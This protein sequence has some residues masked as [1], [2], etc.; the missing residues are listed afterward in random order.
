MAAQKPEMIAR[1]L[2]AQAGVEINGKN[3]WDI[4]VHNP[5]LYSRVLQET[6]MGLGEVLH[7]RLVGLRSP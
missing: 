1:E 7:G 4:Q 2:L 6:S 3:P 5:N